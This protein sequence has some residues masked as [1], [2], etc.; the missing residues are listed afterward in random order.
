MQSS[1]LIFIS[2]QQ[3]PVLKPGCYAL[4]HPLPPAPLPQGK[5]C[6]EKGWVHS[7]QPEHRQTITC[8]GQSTSCLSNGREIPQRSLKNTL[9]LPVV[10]PESQDLADELWCRVN[11][12][13]DMLQHTPWQDIAIE[14]QNAL[15]LVQHI[16][17]PT[18]GLSV[19]DP[20]S[21][22]TT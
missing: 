13:R 10:V 17:E 8:R 22:P 5:V 12:L 21:T 2:L 11:N 16:D 19:R 15:N 18:L 14:P 3:L 4:A 9:V 20:S 7:K 1:V 6:H